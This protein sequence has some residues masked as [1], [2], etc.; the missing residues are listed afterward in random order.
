M[1][2]YQAISFQVSQ[3]QRQHALCDSFY[4]TL[5]FGKSQS[6]ITRDGKAPDDLHGPLVTESRADSI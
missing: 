6:T 1:A 4:L 5:D 3:C 2:F